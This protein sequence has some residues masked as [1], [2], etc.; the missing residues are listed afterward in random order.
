L[1]SVNTT[2]EGW[3]HW[4]CGQ[5]NHVEE[6]AQALVVTDERFWALHSYSGA[7]SHF[8]HVSVLHITNRLNYLK[9]FYSSCAKSI[10][11]DWFQK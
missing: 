6:D 2:G 7:T 1:E 5:R 8:E 10:S 4:L 11:Y 3:E 9:K